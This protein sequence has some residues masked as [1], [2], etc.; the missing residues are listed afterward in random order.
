MLAIAD[1]GCGIDPDQLKRI[2]VPFFT[3]K[4]VGKGTGLG[5]ST[6]YG[7]VEGLGGN[8]TVT[9]EINVGSVFKVHLPRAVSLKK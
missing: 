9:S 1:N 6:C 5:L 2:V 7:I 4:P 3:S 8:I